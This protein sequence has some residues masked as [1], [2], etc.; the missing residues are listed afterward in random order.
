MAVGDKI[1]VPEYGGTKVVFEEQVYG[2]LNAVYPSIITPL[3]F[4]R[5]MS[6]S[7]R[8]IFWVSMKAEKLKHLNLKSLRHN[9]ET[10]I[11]S[12]F[13]S[14][15]ECCA[16]IEGGGARGGSVEKGVKGRREHV[17]WLRETCVTCV[18]GVSALE[19]FS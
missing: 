10:I 1:L 19:T 2:C 16:S 4:F 13:N 6:Y 9:S 18:V 15:Q 3:L 14:A 11:F 12:L 17:T 5:I 7:E 8:V